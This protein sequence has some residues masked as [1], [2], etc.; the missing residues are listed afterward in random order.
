MFCCCCFF[1][2]DLCVVVNY[3]LLL[4]L[5]CGIDSSNFKLLQLALLERLFL[6]GISKKI[7][8]FVLNALQANLFTDFLFVVR[9]VYT[10]SRLTKREAILHSYRYIGTRF[11]KLFYGSNKNIFHVLCDLFGCYF[12]VCFHN[13][14]N[15]LL[16]AFTK[17]IFITLVGNDLII[18]TYISTNKIMFAG[19]FIIMAIDVGSPY[20][21]A[22]V[23][24]A[25]AQYSLEGSKVLMSLRNIECRPVSVLLGREQ[26]T[27][28]I[29]EESIVV[30]TKFSK[31][32][33]FS[34]TCFAQNWVR[35]IFF[36]YCYQL[37]L[38]TERR[39]QFDSLRS[40]F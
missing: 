14:L 24:V 5:I 9:W 25:C 20:F 16:Y 1:A 36:F 40:I 32:Y 31:I 10:S 11:T 35:T 33:F 34:I 39:P 19:R 23:M 12:N 8:D 18:I 6:Q 26:I 21:I 3:Y 4:S 29:F 13:C 2:M 38:S 15:L 30:F 37:T 7:P 27:L 17:L 22:I 28:S